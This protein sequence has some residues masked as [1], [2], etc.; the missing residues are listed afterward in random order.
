[1]RD[2][3]PAILAFAV[4]AIAVALAAIYWTFQGESNDA[5]GK[6]LS[7]LDAFAV[8]AMAN[9]TVSGDPAVPGAV[10]FIDG[11]GAERSLE[12]WRGKVLLVNLWATWCAPCRHEMPALDRLEKALGGPDFE[13][14][15]ISLDRGGLDLPRDFYAEIGIEH[16]DL[17]NDATARAGVTLGAFG[18]PTTVLI[19]RD[20]RLVGRLVGP[21]EWDAPEALALI[22]A[23]IEGD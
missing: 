3:K 2:Q 15:A 22:A 21:A 13:V 18:M 12:D 4:L 8:G 7:K 5:A 20:G 11:T 10:S 9:F 1:M 14:L 6:T 19:D 17:Y 23:A 16:L